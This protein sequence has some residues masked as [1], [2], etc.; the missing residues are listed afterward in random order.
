MQLIETE[1]SRKEFAS[2]KSGMTHSSFQELKIITF[3][4]C[5]IP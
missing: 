3:S 1:A 5:N 4:T 2:N